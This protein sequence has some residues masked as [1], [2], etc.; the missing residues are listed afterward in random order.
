MVPRFRRRDGP[1]RGDHEDNIRRPVDLEQ[2][3]AQLDLVAVP[4]VMPN[5]LLEVE[6][7]R[8]VPRWTT[9]EKSAGEHRSR[10]STRRPR[11]MTLIECFPGRQNRGVAGFKMAHR[12]NVTAH[13][14]KPC[15]SGTSV[16]GPSSVK[17]RGGAEQS[18]P[19]GH[20]TQGH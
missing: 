3:H 5:R 7:P 11:S 2:V 13:V 19:A 20:R 4:V 15:S 14:F 6:G 10:R 17:K 9:A 12:A 8:S 16:P 18:P 1:I